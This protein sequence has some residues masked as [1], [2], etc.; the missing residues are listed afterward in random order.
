VAGADLVTSLRQ[1]GV[2]RGDLVALVISPALE[3]GLATA[4]SSW[5]IA[6]IAGEVGRADEALR[7][8]WAVWSGQTAARLAADGVRLAT[9]WDITAAHRLLFGGWRADPGWAWARL[10][11]LAADT[12]PADGPLDLFGPDPF[13]GDEGDAS[14]P[15]APDGHLRPE[16]VTGGWWDSPGRIARWAALALDVA[17]QQQAALAG[18]NDRPAAVATARCESTAELLCAELSAD[19]L[20]M[21]RAV[22]ERLLAPIIG[23]RPRSE[24]EAVALRAARDAEVLRHAPAGV[25]ADLRS[26]AQVRTLLAKVGV[27]VPDTRAWRLREMKDTHR[28]VG[29][30]LEWRKAERI[31]TTYGYAWLDEHLGADGRLRGA[32]TGSDGAAGRMTA[33]AGLHNMPAALRPAV[34]AADGHVFVRADLGQIEPRVLAAVTGD[35]ALTVA[36][37]SDD[38]YAP[39][40]AQLGVERPVAK[41]AVLGAMYGQTT[42]HGAQAL[43]RLN[44]A[45]PVAMA[46][47]DSADRAGRAGRDLRTYGGRLIVLEPAPGQEPR[48]GSR[49]AAYGRYA[50][51]AMIQGAAAEL[52]KMWAVTVR[53]RCAPL[54]ARIVLC[55]HD[56]LLVHCPRE[57]AETASRLVDDCLQEAARRWAPGCGVRFIS[58]T[59]IVRCWSDAKNGAA[60][61]LADPL[62]RAQR[63]DGLG[64]ARRPGFRLL[65]LFHPA[66]P[67]LAVGEGKPVERRPGGVVAREHLREIRGH[68]DLARRGVRLDADID[69]VTGRDARRRPVLRAERD[70]E[71]PAHP[72]DRRPVGMPADGHGHR[73]A[74]A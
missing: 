50:R 57:H 27:D 60:R 40:A 15:V 37:R 10:R 62:A 5:A 56:E 21:D 31:A 70:E 4:D 8:R 38:L 55:L 17:G 33:S 53:A 9:C 3:F 13:G 23:P 34:M 46:Y 42:G 71:P 19:G 11:G 59:T 52:F 18:L 25:T 41:V 22:A 6:G 30:L 66:H 49:A 7:P 24:A 72:R 67:L 26:P 64:Q 74:V 16:W 36:T 68:V 45:Y 20:P 2:K 51:N 12:M 47:L 43:R 63:L 1:T 28:L 39:V 69:Q 58:D 48:S 73:R 29:A 54:G 65:G 35:Q 32:W 44:A 61:G 14:D